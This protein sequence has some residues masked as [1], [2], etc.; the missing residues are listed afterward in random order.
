MRGAAHQKFGV[1][2]DRMQEGREKK[3][4]G[5][6]G[7]GAEWR[8][9]AWLGL[10]RLVERRGGVGGVVCLAQRRKGAKA[11]RV[12]VA[13]PLG[14]LGGEARSAAKP[15]AALRLCATSKRTLRRPLTTR[16][17]G[18]GGA[19]K[20]SGPPGL[21]DRP[22]RGRLRGPATPRPPGAERV[23][24]DNGGSGLLRLALGERSLT[25]RFFKPAGRVTLPVTE[26]VE[27]GCPRSPARS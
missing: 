25:T 27:T 16:R 1:W 10:A 9:S 13:G 4:G 12:D 2:G 23:G 18:W 21:W 20:R 3:V 22:R 5:G 17:G 19:L 14:P 7:G 15:L 8:G 11:G 6:G 24:L 26:G